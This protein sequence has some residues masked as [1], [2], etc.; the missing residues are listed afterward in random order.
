MR[1]AAAHTCR[2]AALGRLTVAP[3]ALASR[4][5]SLNPVNWFRKRA[6]EDLEGGFTNKIGRSTNPSLEDELPEVFANQPQEVDDYI[7]PDKSFFEQLEDWWDFIATFLQPVD[8]QISILRSWHSSGPFGTGIDLG[9]WG[10]TFLV[11][12]FV[13]RCVTL[14]PAL[15][16]HRNS[17]R[18]AKINPQLA[19]FNEVI[20]RTKQDKTLT[21]V[22]RRVIQDGYKRMKKQLCT[23]NKCAQWKT[24]AALVSMP[25]TISAFLGIRKMVVYESDLEKTPFLWM[26]D[27]T[28][29]DPTYILP[30]MCAS[31][32]YANFELNQAMTKG[33]RSSTTMYIRWACR[34]GLVGFVYFAADTQPAAMF[35]YWLGMSLA[36]ILQPLLL[37]VQWFRTTFGF[38]D[39]PEA[40]KANIIGSS[41][42]GPSMYERIFATPEE[43]A[44]LANERR[45]KLEEEKTSKA[46]QRID[47]FEVIIEKDMPKKGGKS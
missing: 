27:L 37:R 33:T 40:A 20:K 12:G 31:L 14:I 36:G 18:L 25:V 2:L 26:T 9:G 30:T 13:V 3:I 15:Y 32:F 21:T 28:I 45:K 7:R 39:P 38:P 47:D 24:G 19:Q 44:K 29:P 17:L 4:Q 16:S 1:R 34:V 46:Y 23:Q 5:V 35:A 22:E 42:K 41:V 11:Y 6:E 8:K 43:K 10:P